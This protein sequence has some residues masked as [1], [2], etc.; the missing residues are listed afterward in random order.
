M[1]RVKHLYFTLKYV[2]YWTLA[3]MFYAFLKFYGIDTLGLEENNHI[4]FK[5]LLLH[6]IYIGVLLGIFFALIEFAFQKTVIKRLA[7]W[8]LLLIKS[9]AYFVTLV[10]LLTLIRTL[11]LNDGIQPFSIERWW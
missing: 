8:L 10:A 3:F 2:L 7:L 4:T 9:S 11:V 5:N 6:A 1:S